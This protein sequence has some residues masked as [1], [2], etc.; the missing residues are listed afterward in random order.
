MNKSNLFTLNTFRCL[1]LLSTFTA[2]MNVNISHAEI[3]IMVGKRNYLI[4]MLI[5]CVIRCLPGPCRNAESWHVT[6]G[7]CN[8]EVFKWSWRSSVSRMLPESVL[9]KLYWGY[10]WLI[11]AKPPFLHLTHSYMLHEYRLI[12]S[13]PSSSDSGM[14]QFYRFSQ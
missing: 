7:R 10:P 5:F 11:I 14:L 2:G 1:D 8:M 6:E 3:R 4:K 9:L 13:Q 12:I